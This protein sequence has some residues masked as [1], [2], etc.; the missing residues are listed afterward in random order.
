MANVFEEVVSGAEPPKKKLNVFE[1]V[2]SEEPPFNP[3]NF[4]AV[5]EKKGGRPPI[6]KS[7]MPSMGGSFVRGAAS[8]AIPSAVG[9]RVGTA[10]TALAAPVMGPFA[11]VAG[12]IAGIGAGIG[13]RW[14]QEKALDVVAPKVKTT[15]ELDRQINPWSSAAG[16]V[17][18]M[19]PWT[20]V[21]K[22]LLT[23]PRS[24][25]DAVI[26]GQTLSAAEKN[27][28]YGT[29]LSGGVSAGFPA[30]RAIRGQEVTWPDIAEAAA[31]FAMGQPTKL[32]QRYMGLKPTDIAELTA[33]AKLADA[34]VA[35][36]R[37]APAG[38][39]MHGLD[40]RKMAPVGD[41]AADPAKVRSEFLKERA[42]L[43]EATELAADTGYVPPE[44]YKVGEK[45]PG[46]G[47]TAKAEFTTRPQKITTDHP[48]DLYPQETAMRQ[49][50]E[51][52]AKIQ[53]AERKSAAL[54][55]A[56]VEAQEAKLAAIEEQNKQ[57]ATEL[58]EVVT[59]E[60]VVPEKGRL[61]TKP[62]LETQ[63][64]PE[65]PEP[66][67]LISTKPPEAEAPK[68][69]E[70]EPS[71]LAE[72]KQE[73]NPLE[74][75]EPPIPLTTKAPP[76]QS[77]QTIKQ[78]QAAPQVTTAK[79]AEEGKR[80][81]W[82]WHDI[83]KRLGVARNVKVEADGSIVSQKTG[84]PIS[85][86]VAIR[87]GL[88]EVAAKI[89]PEKAGWDTHPHE[90][91]HPL[92]R[93]WLTGPSKTSKRIAQ[94]ALDVASTDPKRPVDV[95][96]EEWLVQNIGEGTAERLLDSRY[97]SA[98][99]DFWAHAKVKLGRGSMADYKRLFSNKLIGDA[100]FADT[101]PAPKT[102]A[103]KPVDTGEE[104]PKQE[105]KESEFFNIGPRA[106]RQK[107][108]G[109]NVVNRPLPTD[110][111]KG[112]LENASKKGIIP[113]AELDAYKKAGFDE[114]LANSPR[115]T[116]EEVAKWMDENGPKA[117]V[118]TY[119]MEGS[120]TKVK[121]E[122]D[123]LQHELDSLGY[124]IETNGKIARN[125]S[126]FVLERDNPNVPA[127]AWEMAD[128]IEELRPQ[129]T[130]DASVR[131]T[132]IYETV[133]PF[134]TRE[135]MPEWTTSKEG[136]NVQRVDVVVPIK[137][138]RS[139][140]SWTPAWVQD[141]LHENLPNTLGW[142]MIQYRTGPNGEKIAV[143]TEAQSR[144]G[145]TVRK[146]KEANVPESRLRQLRNEGI[147]TRPQEGHPLLADYNRL[148]MKAAIEQAQK[149]GA[150]HI[151]LSDAETAMMSEGHDAHPVKNVQYYASSK[152]E[153]IELLLKDF[154]TAKVDSIRL[155][156]NV[157]LGDKGDYA[158]RLKEPVISQEGGMRLNYDTILPKIAQDLTGQKGTPIDLGPHKNAF[159]KEDSR[160][161][162]A[163]GVSQRQRDNLI[164]KNPDGTPKT[165]VTG[166]MYPIAKA[167][168]KLEANKGFSTFG[169]KEQAA[170]GIPT[171]KPEDRAPVRLPTGI[172]KRMAP[173][174]DRI[175]EYG[176]EPAIRLANAFEDFYE[177][178]REYKGK[179]I[180]QPLDKIRPLLGIQ[181]SIY[182][183]DPQSWI[184]QNTESAK[185]VMQ[186]GQDIDEFGKSSV[187]LTDKEN[188][189]Y[190]VVRDYF[191]ES[192]DWRNARPGLTNMEL[193]DKYWP[194]MIDSRVMSKLINDP[195][196]GKP[197]T[198]KLWKDFEDYQL[199]K[200][201]TPEEIQQ[202]K[203]D[204]IKAWTTAKGSDIARQFG[205]LD[206]PRGIGIPPSWREQNLVKLIQRF[207]DRISRRFAYH[208]TLQADQHPDI[209]E[210]SDTFRPP[211]VQAIERDIMGHRPQIEVI[212]EAVGGIARAGRLGTQTGIN[213]L[214]SAHTL[215]SQHASGFGQHARATL[216]AYRNFAKNRAEARA[217]GLIRDN[218]T[219][220]ENIEFEGGSALE[221]TRRV[222]DVLSEGQGRNLLEQTSRAISYGQG[223]LMAEE[224]L[225]KYAQGKTLSKGERRFLQN[226]G[227]G[228]DWES[229]VKKGK[230][231]PEEIIRKM[232]GRFVESTQG[233]YDYRGQPQFTMEG[234]GA[235]ITQLARW[236]IEKFNNFMKHVVTPLVR[237]ND[238][239]PL[240]R[241][242]LLSLGGGAAIQMVREEL[243]GRKQKTATVPEIKEA[244]KKSAT[245][246]ELEL[247]YKLATLLS[248]AGF[249]GI[250]LDLAK[251]AFDRMYAKSKTDFYNAPALDFL[252]DAT[253]DLMDAANT[254]ME[255]GNPGETAV[256]LLTKTLTDNVQLLRLL[257]ANLNP[258][259]KK[260]IE[261]QN[262]A[263][264]LNV[265]KRIDDPSKT[266]STQPPE[267]AFANKKEKKFTHAESPEELAQTMI[268]VVQKLVDRYRNDP[269]KF[270]DA[271]EG[272][273][274]S[275]PEA[276]APTVSGKKDY[277]GMQDLVEFATFLKNTQGEEAAIERV[278][279]DV[280]KAKELQKLRTGL[281]DAMKTLMQK[282]IVEEGGSVPDLK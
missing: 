143:I 160:Q 281:V 89:N 190:E 274:Q 162:G 238:W 92:I 9:F 37:T 175:R 7:A 33:R 112:Q 245:K 12:I 202:A 257:D 117:E 270:L 216:S 110:Q 136:R 268:P 207:G 132:S 236:N 42:A 234:G 131:A 101:H 4:A 130:Q 3:E 39:P 243:S 217:E 94:N 206:R 88:E 28:L 233:T 62:Y 180:T 184:S 170:P 55:A 201:K 26:N 192:G 60:T 6:P 63:T 187:K 128:R 258:E 109:E 47:L 77:Q 142:A 212:R 269:L 147:D 211:E 57:K 140:Q 163:L 83:F 227:K 146:D 279:T 23:L 87:Q 29:A 169:R 164:F 78:E 254:S 126:S 27:Y 145:Q 196:N 158:I 20:K 17:A 123:T 66:A 220:L 2:A 149:E 86:N 40:V 45:I 267:S 68:F 264:D 157:K 241:M 134:N 222:R 237:E 168:A 10:A 44:T 197:E 74:D 65:Q 193:Y 41:F 129:A 148:I 182:G 228:T 232:A 271:L 30:Y 46:S 230:E 25:R 185:R 135:P 272:L 194:Q 242:F 226:F 22:A 188:Q 273:K 115:K 239:G 262:K 127:K 231:I 214:I 198:Q 138:G 72:A 19:S 256:N 210:I 59:G 248:Y 240:S 191:K 195:V 213:D 120:S 93:D 199:K 218:I 56:K 105:Q 204:L 151:F 81:T 108:F 165:S 137:G 186:Y 183:M 277:A 61:T 116:P 111:L 107:M 133:S 121:Q 178:F 84:Q 173:M 67:P 103:V 5:A 155:T 252:G 167:A 113:P 98:L 219:S 153:A 122:F 229:A 91:A 246:G 100:P 85:G 76:T 125:G 80:V 32:G 15:L 119:G 104:A 150:D 73:F 13:T 82:T 18:S 58:M 97:D 75:Y 71:V 124:H 263:R 24:V 176:S 225:I 38:P 161:H 64:K 221:A 102:P 259:T 35:D 118:H 223:R 90:L 152:D 16:R 203:K 265:F 99:R 34:T 179:W 244:F 266:S 156:E 251:T 171:I 95:D 255:E 253:A 235:W 14:A 275:K 11:P 215:G 52:Q 159:G 280:A 276:V 21:D 247:G 200:G 114:W 209:K 261:R 174:I 31:G 172:G 54:T 8:E 50:A 70:D 260:N 43:D 181:R 144:W 48:I 278:I 189:A 250:S 249:G 1:Q 53:A 96:A 49:E 79:P 69:A 139:V 208:D 205:P 36:A 106:I 177:K 141:N 166:L 154:P 224:N 282:K 51:L